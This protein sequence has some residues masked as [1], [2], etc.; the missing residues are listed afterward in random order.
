MSIEL[1]WEPIELSCDDITNVFV[2][3]K[4]I[5]VEDLFERR[6]ILSTSIAKRQFLYHLGLKYRSTLDNKDRQKIITDAVMQRGE[7][8]RVER[9]YPLVFRKISFAGDDIIVGSVV[10]IEY[11]EIPVTEV[12]E[13]FEEYLTAFNIGFENVTVS[14]GNIRDLFGYQLNKSYG[15]LLSVGHSGTCSIKVYSGYTIS[16]CHNNI[17]GKGFGYI[18]HKSYPKEELLKQLPIIITSA[19]K[20][21]KLF[22]ILIESAKKPIDEKELGEIFLDNIQH[23]PE[24]I[25]EKLNV[26]Y[27]GKY[28]TEKGLWK[29]SQCL[30]DVGSNS[31]GI[32]ENYQRTLQR[33]AFRILEA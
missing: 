26:L 7:K 33:H 29:I 17:I 15:L 13:K 20:Y 16:S 8:E 9:L 1:E 5:I 18:I 19:L 31:E 28:K 22:P 30:S 12:K 2:E 25:Q 6:F 14:R 3:E 24:H 10:T 32:T 27:N 23:Y 21:L 4:E 11:V